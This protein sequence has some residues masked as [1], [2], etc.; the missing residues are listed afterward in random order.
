MRV[1][2]YRPQ[3]DRI[4]DGRQ[5]LDPR[6]QLVAATG[7]VLEHQPDR[8]RRL[9]QG[10]PH[11]VG[12]PPEPDI[13]PDAAVGADVRVDE[14]R[15][16]GR[17]ALQ[18]VGQAG[19]RLAGERLG[20]ACEVDQVGR[21]DRDRPDPLAAQYAMNSSASGGGSGR[22]RHAVGL[23]LK[24]WSARAP[25]CLDRRAARSSPCPTPRWSPTQ[26]PRPATSG[27]VAALAVLGCGP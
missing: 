20:G 19:A 4:Q 1:G 6:A 12:D 7:R 3:A 21:M 11:A 27:A 18:L 14:R 24:I 25:I 15:T 26:A 9:L 5:L 22:R 17:S 10:G 16:V 8:W 13:C 23:S 2:R